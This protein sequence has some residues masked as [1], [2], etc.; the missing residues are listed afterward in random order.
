V[1]SRWEIHAVP[2]GLNILGFNDFILLV[3]VDDIPINSGEHMV[4]SMNSEN[5]QATRELVRLSYKPYF[6]YQLAVLFSH[7]KSA[8]ITFSHGFSDNKRVRIV[9]IIAELH[10]LISSTKKI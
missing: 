1:G 5:E 4:S 2:E 10:I 8:N 9:V 7:N 6:F 3:V